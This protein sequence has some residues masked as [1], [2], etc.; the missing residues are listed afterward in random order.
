MDSSVRDHGSEV[1]GPYSTF[2]RHHYGQPNEGG[3]ANAKSASGSGLPMTQSITQ[4]FSSSGK[5]GGG[6]RSGDDGGYAKPSSIGGADGSFGASHGGDFGGDF[7]KV[8]FDKPLFNTAVSSK[9][10]NGGPSPRSLYSSNIG[11]STSQSKN[12][13]GPDRHHHHGPPQ[14]LV[15]IDSGAPQH[16]IR[17][18][19]PLA[20][21][22]SKQ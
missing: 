9:D 20:S 18:D 1:M 8:D 19:M 17:T 3:S 15:S 11:G 10:D 14:K 7:S 4:I 6:M 2:E 13:A 5:T 21:E 16:S 22:I 12:P